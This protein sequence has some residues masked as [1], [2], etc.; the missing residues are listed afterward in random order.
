MIFFWFYFSGLSS[1]IMRKIFSHWGLEPVYWKDSRVNTVV[2]NKYI[3]K[4]IGMVMHCT[5]L[6]NIC[7]QMVWTCHRRAVTNLLLPL[8][9]VSF[10]FYPVNP[11]SA[12]QNCCSKL[13]QMTSVFFFC[14]F[15]FSEQIRCS[16]SCES[17]ARQMIH[18]KCHVLFPLKNSKKNPKK[19]QNIVCY[20]FA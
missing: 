10:L 11:W 20:S 4:E 15:Y 19:Q 16:I 17:P 5:G 9:H 1:R 3:E 14:F 12:V 6:M 2:I 13:Q 18:M 7:I 8:H